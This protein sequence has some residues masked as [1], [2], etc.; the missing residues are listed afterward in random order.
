MTYLMSWLKQPGLLKECFLD[1]DKRLMP[2]FCLIKEKC[3]EIQNCNK[4]AFY[5]GRVYSWQKDS[6]KVL[7]LGWLSFN[8][9]QNSF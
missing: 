8:L 5:K 7:V 6:T 1:H 4:I 3:F 9:V 2:I